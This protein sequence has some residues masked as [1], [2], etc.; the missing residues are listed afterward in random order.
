MNRSGKPPKFESGE[1]VITLWLEFCDSIVDGDFKQIP[2][3]AA[4]CRWL[5]EHYAETS[6]RTLY[7]AL[8]KYFPTIK[9]EFRQIQSDVIMQGGMLGKYNPTMAIFGLKNWC[10]WCNDG[11][12]HNSIDERPE[13]AL[14]KALRE[15]AEKMEAEC[16]WMNSERN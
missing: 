8:N 9:K 1:Q 12:T 14:S 16:E 5:G 13:D 4:F 6:E 2:T 10:G 15:E 3:Q 7:N 11:T